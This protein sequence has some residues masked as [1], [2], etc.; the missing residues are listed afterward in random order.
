MQKDTEI[1][2]LEFRQYNNYTC[3]VKLLSIYASIR[4]KREQA[5]E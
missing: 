3:Y 1:R 2:D 5:F 4:S